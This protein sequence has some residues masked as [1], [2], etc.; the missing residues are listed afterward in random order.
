MRASVT[1]SAR[2]ARPSAPPTRH[3]AKNLD[4]GVFA[5]VKDD[6]KRAGLR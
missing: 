5:A 3:A 2:K 6:W 1:I 4:A